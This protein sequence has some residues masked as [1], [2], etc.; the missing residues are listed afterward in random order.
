MAD[1]VN[2]TNMSSSESLSELMSLPAFNE[3]TA[4][5]LKLDGKYLEN[6]F[7]IYW[8][9]AQREINEIGQ[10]LDDADQTQ[11]RKVAHSLKGS[12]RMLGGERLG[13]LAGFVEEKAKQNVS[14]SEPQLLDC[15]NTSLAEFKSA[16]LQSN[17]LS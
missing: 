1:Q 7:N 9:S 5:A 8:E 6:V 2:V 12:S 15:L 3:A 4:I 11:L 16:V 10:V 17:L 14:I 13:A